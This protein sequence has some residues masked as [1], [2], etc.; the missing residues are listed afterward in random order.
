MTGAPSIP[1]RSTPV[2]VG[3]SGGVDSAVAAL[4]LRRAGIPVQGLFMSNWDEDDA[5]CTVSADF[6]DARA[7]CRE[8]GIPLHRVSFAEEYRQ[9]V[10]A[11]FLVEHRK[12]RTPNPDVLCNREIK[13]GVCL[14]YARRLGGECLAT[15]HYA[16]RV[17][18]TDGPALLKGVDPGKDQSYFLHAI[19]RAELAR[20]IFPLGELPKAEVRAMAREAGL[21]VHDKRDSTGICFIGERPFREFLARHIDPTPGPIE[22]DSG[23]RLGEHAGLAFHTIG[24]RSGL[25]IGGRASRPESPWYAAIKD[26]ARNVLVVVQGHDHPLLMSIGLES[27]RAHW[28]VDPPVCPFDAT[29]KLRHRHPD[30]SALVTPLPDGRLRVDFA[31]PQRAVAA[32]QSVVIYSG[33]RCLGGAVIERTIPLP[34][35][36]AAGGVTV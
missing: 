16:R 28:L 22:S 26:T 1:D 31:E 24:Q 29:V 25:G 3:I 35:R 36:G 34:R 12:G 8:L 27:E 20:A 23:E 10:F 14:A 21:P 30:Q 11:D 5:Y 17:D 15:G 13:F 33:E 19:G 6:Q 2:I 4:L 9:R 32:G 18:G 7:V